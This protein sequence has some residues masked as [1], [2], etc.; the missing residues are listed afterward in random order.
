M[1]ECPACGVPYADHVGLI[2]TC[3]EAQRLT[4]LLSESQKEIERLRQDDNFTAL[5]LRR[6]AK[7]LGIEN[8][9]PDDETSAR[10][11]GT[12]LGMIAREVE[13]QNTWIENDKEIFALFGDFPDGPTIKQAREW[14]A[15][16]KAEGFREGVTKAAEVAEELAK[17]QLHGEIFIMEDM[18]PAIRSLIKDDN[19]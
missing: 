2:G 12:V 17:R 11:A 15:T 13:K 18:A 7:L 14:L 16:S 19:K 5:R 8:A 4:S 3:K 9:L 6:V 1:D 10:C